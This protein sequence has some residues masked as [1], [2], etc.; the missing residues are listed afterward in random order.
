MVACE[1]LP[2]ARWVTNSINVDSDAG[3]VRRLVALQKL[4][5]RRMPAA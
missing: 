1:M 2:V 5:Y 3:K 4:V